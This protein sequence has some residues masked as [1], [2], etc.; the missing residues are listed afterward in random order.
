MT[1]V[2]RRTATGLMVDKLLCMEL[3]LIAENYEVALPQDVD[4]SSK[5]KSLVLRLQKKFNQNVVVIIDE[6]DKPLLDV[7][8]ND[9]AFDEILGLFKSFYE[10]LKLL[11]GQLRFVFATGVFKFAKVGMFSGANNFA[12]LTFDLQSGTL[13]GYTQKELEEY[14]DEGIKNLSLKLHKSHSEIIAMLQEK[15]NGYHFGYDDDLKTLSNGV[16]NSFGINHVFAANTMIEK[17]FESGSP[18]ILLRKLHAESCLAILHQNLSIEKEALSSTTTP[19]ELAPLPLLYFG[20]YLTID[21]YDA[22]LKQLTLNFPN[23]EV[24]NAFARSLIREIAPNTINAIALIAAKITKSFWE[25]Q[26]DQLKDLFNQALANIG[27]QLLL[28]QERQYQI[29]FFMLLNAG[30]LRTR[31]EEVTQDGRIDISVEMRHT[32]YIIELKIDEAP[33]KAIAQIKTKDYAKKYRHLDLPIWGIGVKLAGAPK[34]E[35]S[36]KNAVL[37]LLAERL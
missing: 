8:D 13:L 12:D 3:E 29:A 5:L 24:S 17:W 26:F 33:E 28:S 16:Y 11:T 15:Y 2:A 14:F 36:K 34:K 1:A 35:T 7:I 18:S 27:Y 30:N 9:Q 25:Q 19:S 10:Q 20:G 21:S 4:A 37:A 32:I 23:T 22:T 31:I 6:Y